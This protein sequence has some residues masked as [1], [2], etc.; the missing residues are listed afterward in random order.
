MFQQL[1]N[2]AYRQG[3]VLIVPVQGLNAENYN[4]HREDRPEKGGFVLAA[5]EAT[6]HHH[7]VKT[8]G[9]KMF[10]DGSR[11]FLR[12]P[13]SAT[14]THEEHDS[15]RLPKGDYE[16]VRQREFQPNTAPRRVY[17]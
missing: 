1:M 11:R 17:D 6:G 7:R 15:I 2:K 16:I 3:D 4:V 5:G 13:T 9:V 10:R 8:R 14:V 12:V